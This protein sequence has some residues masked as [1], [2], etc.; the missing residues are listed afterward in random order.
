MVIDRIE[1]Q[2]AVGA[3]VG[4]LGRFTQAEWKDYV[5]ELAQEADPNQHGPL[6]QNLD[7]AIRCHHL[8][9]RV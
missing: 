3:I 6:P 7:L 2:E 9:Q 4:Q 5:L 1:M 8:R